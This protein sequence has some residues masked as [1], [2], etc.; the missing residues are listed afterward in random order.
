MWPYTVEWVSGGP[1]VPTHQCVKEDNW[2]KALEAL[3]GSVNLAPFH[4]GNNLIFIACR[5]YVNLWK[6]KNQYTSL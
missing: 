5:E 2:V 4:S 6:D 3:P 1:V